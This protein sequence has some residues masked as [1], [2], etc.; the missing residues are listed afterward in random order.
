MSS[1]QASL[2]GRLGKQPETRETKNGN[3]M[4]TTTVA[5]K[6]N[7]ADQD[8]LTEWVSLTAFGRAGEELARHV[9]GDAISASGRMSKSRYTGRDGDE[10]ESW[11]LTVDAV[12]SAR[13]VRP[14][15]GRTP[16]DDAPAPEFDDE[17]GF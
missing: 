17:V 2:Y 11:Q 12:I 5:V 6:V 3:A 4:T 15:A 9:K 10:R 7:R 13:T 16:A 14:T 8:E 1:L